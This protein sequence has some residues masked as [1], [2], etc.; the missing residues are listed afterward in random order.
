MRLEISVVKH[1]NCSVCEISFI[2]LNDNIPVQ[3][4]YLNV[5]LYLAD[6]IYLLLWEESGDIILVMNVKNNINNQHLKNTQI[7]NSTKFTCAWI[8]LL[9]I[10]SKKLL[11]IPEM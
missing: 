10:G 4:S 2:S 6:K 9:F 1:A 3:F 8:F 7:P 11:N 5:C